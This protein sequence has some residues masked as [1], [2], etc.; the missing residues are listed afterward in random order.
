MF[1]R[2]MH[3]FGPGAFA[4]GEAPEKQ[5]KMFCWFILTIC[6]NRSFE[7]FFFDKCKNFIIN[8]VREI[9]IFLFMKVHVSACFPKQMTCRPNRRM[10][11]VWIIGG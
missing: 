11:L 9:Q 2:W 3:A 10:S 5:E 8:Y 4:R 6:S 1:H 7:P